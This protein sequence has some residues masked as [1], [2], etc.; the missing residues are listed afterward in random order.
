MARTCD[1]KMEAIGQ[2]GEEQMAKFA[3]V[4]N[5]V[6]SEQ[7]VCSDRRRLRNRL[8]LGVG[9]CRCTRWRF[10]FQSD[11]MCGWGDMTSCCFVLLTPQIGRKRSS[12][13]TAAPNATKL[14]EVVEGVDRCLYVKKSTE[15]TRF[16]GDK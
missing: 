15:I 5:S 8:K 10:E 6:R 12:A 13:G 4:L 16:R 9:C 11:R 2:E 3:Q 1:V 14:K 7:G